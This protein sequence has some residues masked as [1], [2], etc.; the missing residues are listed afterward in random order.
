LI[1]NEFAARR[2]N[3]VK[4]DKNT[5]QEESLKNARV[6][7]AEFTSTKISCL[8]LKARESYLNLLEDVMKENYE[9]VQNVSDC[10]RVLAK[11]CASSFFQNLNTF[12]YM[13]TIPE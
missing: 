13:F 11:V 4:N 5:I 2:K 1:K 9:K 10:Q 6:R 12:H 8:E 3:V 7:G